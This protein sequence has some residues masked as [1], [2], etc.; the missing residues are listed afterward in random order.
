VVLAAYRRAIRRTIHRIAER[1]RSFAEI[2]PGIHRALT[3][4]FPYAI[5]FAEENEQ[6]VILAVK[7]QAQDPASWP[8]G[9]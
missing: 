7:H 1:P 5:F 6:I 3:P 2:L 9:T 4:Q 8:S